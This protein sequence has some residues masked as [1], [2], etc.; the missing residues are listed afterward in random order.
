MPPSPDVIISERSLGQSY[1][2]YA[3][4]TP[5]VDKMSG[6]GL[7]GSVSRFPSNCATSQ[8]ENECSKQC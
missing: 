1:R 6:A 3:Y 5:I 8:G 2:R 7:R 4:D